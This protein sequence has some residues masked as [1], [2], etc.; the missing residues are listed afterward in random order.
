MDRL[1]DAEA[2]G[3]FLYNR[4]RHSN[5]IWGDHEASVAAMVSTETIGKVQH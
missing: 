1:K 4:F 3:R 5:K 2:C